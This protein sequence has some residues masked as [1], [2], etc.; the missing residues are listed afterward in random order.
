MREQA[1]AAN[2]PPPQPRG[3]ILGVFN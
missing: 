2:N 1:E 3:G